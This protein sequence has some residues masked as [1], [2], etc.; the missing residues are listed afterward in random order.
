MAP[1]KELLAKQFRSLKRFRGGYEQHQY[2]EEE[3]LDN[4]K[5]DEVRRL[6]LLD[7]TSALETV[8]P[9]AEDVAD[10]S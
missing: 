1:I 10:M 8:R 6:N 9:T 5:T 3:E 2:E 4:S 7:F